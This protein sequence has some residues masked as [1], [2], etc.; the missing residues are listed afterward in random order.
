LTR[1]G[2]SAQKL[3]LGITSGIDCLC[4]THTLMRIPNI[5]YIKTRGKNLEKKATKIDVVNTL[6]LRN[7]V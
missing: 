7:I 3:W 5:R 6:H 4:L 2:K 1:K